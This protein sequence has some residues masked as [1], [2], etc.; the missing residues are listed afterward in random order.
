MLYKI[1]NPDKFVKGKPADQASPIQKPSVAGITLDGAGSPWKKESLPESQQQHVTDSTAVSK[2]LSFENSEYEEMGPDLLDEV[3]ETSEGEKSDA[4]EA[5]FFDESQS[6]PMATEG[7][8]QCGQVNY[9]HQFSY[10]QYPDYQGQ[11]FQYQ[12]PN[13]YPDYSNN[14]YHNM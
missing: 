10:H 7:E 2:V 1:K 3:T 6:P 14:S 9:Y 12:Q 11:C 8:G 5:P 13:Q 4:E